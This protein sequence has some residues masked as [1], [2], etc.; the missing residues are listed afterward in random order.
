MTNK[1]RTRIGQLELEDLKIQDQKL[2][3]LKKRPL[4]LTKT[5]GAK[6]KK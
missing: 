5:L 2:K 4:S 6:T 3:V 1:M